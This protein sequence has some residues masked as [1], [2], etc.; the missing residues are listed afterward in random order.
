MLLASST[1]WVFQFSQ[2]LDS[3]VS[4]KFEINV[5]L[6]VRLTLT[7]IKFKVDLKLLVL[8]NMMRA[9]FE[10]GFITC[11][12]EIKNELRDKLRRKDLDM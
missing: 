10:R 6:K 9:K 1:L 7:S 12:N 11:S 3:L 5:D 4:H 8:L 2:I